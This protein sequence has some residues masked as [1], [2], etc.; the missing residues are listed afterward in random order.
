[1]SVTASVQFSIL[2]GMAEGKN[3]IRLATEEDPIRNI[4]VLEI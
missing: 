1:M 4:F 3:A 2:A